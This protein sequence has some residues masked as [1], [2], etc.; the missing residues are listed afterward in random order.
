[1]PEARARAERR[2]VTRCYA[3]VSPLHHHGCRLDHRFRGHAWCQAQTFSG[4]PG[5]H[6]NEAPAA[7]DV[8]LDLG[9]QALDLH[10]AD[11]SLQPVA[12]TERVR[13][14]AAQPLDLACRDDAPV[15]LVA[16]D[17]DP[18]LAIPAAEGVETDPERPGRLARRVL[19]LWHGR[20]A[21]A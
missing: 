20:E 6:G 17:A 21:S 12:R 10:V 5:D 11:D 1:M 4:L 13:L 19:P 2:Q 16:A 9:Q 15:G 3:R 18:A 7:H 14:L 8:Q